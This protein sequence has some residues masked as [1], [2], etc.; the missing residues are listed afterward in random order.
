[1]VIDDE[2]NKAK[3]EDVELSVGQNNHEDEGVDQEEVDAAEVILEVEKK[4]EISPENIVY[5][6]LSDDA[7][8]AWNA[9]VTAFERTEQKVST[10]DEMI[11]HIETRKSESRGR[12]SYGDIRDQG[13]KLRSDMEESVKG[14][15]DAALEQKD[16]GNDD[17]YGVIKTMINEEIN[18]WEKKLSESE[19]DFGNDRYELDK[20]VDKRDLDKASIAIF[21]EALN[22][23]ERGGGHDTP[24]V[25]D[26][27]DIAKR[28]DGETP[29]EVA[30]KEVE[31]KDIKE[32]LN[33]E[34]YKKMAEMVEKANEEFNKKI[35]KLVKQYEKIKKDIEKNRKQR[36][37][38][39][40]I[41]FNAEIDHP[42][43][44][45][46]KIG[47]R[48]LAKQLELEVDQLTYDNSELLRE[49][50]REFQNAR[51]AMVIN[52]QVDLFDHLRD[53]GL[54]ELMGKESTEYISGANG[55]DMMMYQRKTGVDLDSF[56]VKIRDD[57]NKNLDEL[58]ASLKEKGI[59]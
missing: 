24:V 13:E 20:E 39:G 21:M 15:V 51:E 6:A 19:R 5:R 43:K 44:D 49:V 25:Q 34:G 31:H 59:F 35:E 27:R 52:Q 53:N 54:N 1:M 50:Y 23:F 17:V 30:D 55:P 29:K 3:Q 12:V 16:L 42:D 18:K 37:E 2:K 28:I 48:D 7:K 11:Y 46:E 9:A 56:Y 10:D 32:R 33:E 14:M 8:R 47:K 41:F 36:D 38:M 57:I 58:S 4:E 26:F 40:F 45:G 22:A